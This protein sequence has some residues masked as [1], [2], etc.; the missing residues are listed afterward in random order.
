MK[1]LDSIKQ[2]KA[3]IMDKLAQSIREKDE[4]KMKEAMTEYG[5]FVSEQV[6]AEAQGVVA[7]TDHQILT[8][9]GCRQLTSQETKYYQK[10]ITASK[11]A[12]YKQAIANID[13]AMPFTIVEDVMSDVQQNYELLN[14]LDF[15]NTS[16]VTKW[17]I[18]KEG[19]QI[20]KW[21]ELN[22][23]ITK[24]LEGSIGIID[25]TLC[26]LSAFMVVTMDMLDLGPAWI[27]RYVRAILV[28]ALAVAL[29]TAIVSG[30]GKSEPIGM[31]RSVADDVT[32]TGGVYPQKAAVAVTDFSPKSYGSLIASMAKTRT[33]KAR[34][35]EN[36]I[37]VVNP[38]DYFSLVMPATT[39]QK[40]DGTY[41]NDV[42]P[43]PTKIIQS[44]GMEKGKAII[45]LGKRYFI[46]VGTGKNG[47]LEYDDSVKFLD[48]QRAYKIKL[49]AN[50]QPLDD[51][52]FKVLDISKLQPAFY[53]IK[54]VNGANTSTVAEDKASTGK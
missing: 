47:K 31:N 9:R 22:S 28:D 26:K 2:T 40:P 33:G 15:V 45:G 34:K 24:E 13:V 21:G 44:V 39:L 17:I 27:D 18:N 23:E 48:D 7:V 19:Q 35:I 25:T 54:D 14:A 43:Y 4:K 6:L 5:N 12:D 52:A 42:L 8:A 30:T 3:E 32:V 1:N 10:L 16:G 20:A 50:G 38:E 37:L 11:A 53:A 51:N 46:G 29:E 49:H 36:L 41:A